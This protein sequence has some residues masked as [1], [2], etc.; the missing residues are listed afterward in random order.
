MLMDMFSS[1]DDQNKTIA[2]LAQIMWALP[3]L[4][5]L[6]LMKLKSKMSMKSWMMM[7]MTKVIWNQ[8]KTT[9]MKSLGGSVGW[10]TTLLMVIILLNLTGLSPYTFSMT[11]HLA[12]NLTLSLPLWTAVILASL[13]YNS[14]LFIAH[15]LPE[16]TPTPLNPFICIIELVS[17]LVRPLTLAIRLTANISTGHILMSLLSTPFTTFSPS[18]MMMSTLMGTMYFMFEMAVS[19]VQAYIF[20]LLPALYMDEHPIIHPNPKK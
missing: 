10:M 13:T 17:N 5:T 1:F 11:S 3:I 15:L 19:L 20:T 14:T 8:A 2:N 16:S 12:L 9:K 6:M 7:T 18:S 4:L